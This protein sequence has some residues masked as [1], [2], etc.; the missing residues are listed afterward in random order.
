MK[1]FIMSC[2]LAIVLCT[3]TSHAR[4]GSKRCANVW[5]DGCSTGQLPGAG[6]D[7]DYLNGGF[8]PGKRCVNLW[9]EGCVN[10]QLQ[11]AGGDDEY[12][13]GGFNP[14]KRSLGEVLAKLMAFE[15]QRQH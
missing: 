2:V 14:G 3:M 13:N 10:G 15:R 5:D 1:A 9:D 12:V 4:S 8:T 11:G 6:D 7:D